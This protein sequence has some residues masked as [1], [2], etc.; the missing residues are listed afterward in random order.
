MFAYDDTNA[1]AG[2]DYRCTR[3]LREEQLEF[4][5][6]GFWFWL[7]GVFIRGAGR[8]FDGARWCISKQTMPRANRHGRA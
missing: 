6:N 5:H 1:T 7:E 3:E 2:R 4:S 8:M